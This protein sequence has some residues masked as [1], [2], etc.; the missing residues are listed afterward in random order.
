[1]T[2]P[3]SG[4][5]DQRRCPYVGLQPFEEAD[6]P[7]FFGRERDQRIIIAN[8]L[9]SSLT[10]LYGGSGVGKSSVLMAG[11]LPQLHRERGDTPVVVFREWSRQD[12]YVELKRS[13]IEEAWRTDP[14]R[15]RPSDDESLDE[16]LT[17]CTRAV[18]RPILLILDQFEEYFLYHARPTDPNSFEAQ[19]ARSINRDDVDARFM[20]SL[21]EDGLA[22]LDRFR[23]RIPNLLSNRL[24][25]RHLNSDGAR[26]A[27]RLPLEVW[28]QRYGEEVRIEDELVEALI[29]E[30]RTGQISTSAHAGS[31][32]ARDQSG[33]IE[34]PYL[35]QVLVRL[36]DFEMDSGFRVLRLSTL[37][38]KF[39]GPQAIVRSHLNQVMAEELSA[40]AQAA[41]ASF[42]DRLV[43]PSGAKIA[44]R[45]SD[46][47]DWAE[48]SDRELVSKTLE[49]LASPLLR[50]LRT[51][52]STQDDP[53]STSYEIYHDVLAPAMLDWRQ[54][55][56]AEQERKEAARVAEQDKAKAVKRAKERAEK[57]AL[58]REKAILKRWSVALAI[59]TL[60]AILGW[61]FAYRESLR[62]ESNHL[63]AQSQIALAVD[64]RQGLE[65]ALKAARKT[66]AN[67]FLL[68]GT[69]TAAEDALRRSIQSSRLDWTLEVCG[70]VADLAMSPD[71]SLI[72]VGCTDGNARIWDISGE[73]RVPRATLQHADDTV[74]RR[75]AFL[76]D[77]D[78]LITVGGDTVKLW[79]LDAPQQPLRT[80][81]HG[82]PINEAFALDVDRGRIA[83]AGG[84]RWPAEAKREIKVWDLNGDSDEPI[85]T[86]DT[87]GAWI[88]GLAFSPD[89]CCLATAHV[90]LADPGRKKCDDAQRVSSTAVW[91]IDSGRELLNPKIK[92]ASDAVIFTQD[93]KA[94][95]ATYRDTFVRLW[96]PINGDLGGLQERVR[97]LKEQAAEQRAAA[98]APAELDDDAPATDEPASE[99][100]LTHRTFADEISDAAMSEVTLTPA[101][102]D[103]A[104]GA[105][106]TPESEIPEVCI[107]PEETN[108]LE[109]IFAGHTER[110]RNISISPDGKR[111]ASAGADHL[112]KVWDL[113]TG[114]HLL[115]LKGHSSWVEAVRFSPDG[116]HLATASKD[117]TVKY[118]N[119]SSH[120]GAVNTVAFSPNGKELVTGSSDQKAMVW[121]LGVH[122]PKLLRT[123]DGHT[124]Q[125]YQ[126]AV[127]P[128]GHFIATA[129]FDNRVRI[130]DFQSGKLIASLPHWDS[131]RDVT[132]SD[133]PGYVAT[134]A[135]SGKGRLYELTDTGANQIS[136]ATHSVINTPNFQ[137]ASS[138]LLLGDRKRWITAG[139]DGKL[140][141]WD[142]TSPKAQQ[143]GE[144]AIPDKAGRY[145]FDL[146]LT[147]D[148]KQVAALSY[149]TGRVYVWP[150]EAFSDQNAVVPRTYDVPGTNCTAFAFSP[151]QAKRLLA[152]ACDDAEVHLLD[153]VTGKEVKQISI[154]QRPVVDVAFS[155]ER[156]LLASASLDGSFHVSPL[157]LEDLR[158]QACKLYQENLG[159]VDESDAY[160][161]LGCPGLP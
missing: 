1:M 150:L 61:Y 135:G 26:D 100:A 7:Y 77:N 103:R 85:T 140:K 118:W 143:L 147:P 46:L 116:H 133:P 76:P 102:E 155:P 39:G 27:M 11:V 91:D 92:V 142:F 54:Q 159:T 5:G 78:R 79:S 129:G 51:V 55:Y 31:G 50:I 38:D 48:S 19:L 47:Q 105:I 12:F 122:R 137:Q 95:I 62:A 151:V 49:L 124:D 65:L 126:V 64:A 84:S 41:C 125:V 110:V 9:S 22:K 80:F 83:T 8:L 60:I 139:Y 136:E 152:I 23:A 72:A 145:I 158:L 70:K 119:I 99:G 2:T 52:A 53:N 21:R 42:F 117:G 35:Q 34:A 40:E 89:G 29:K 101:D 157:D 114:E 109:R 18:D 90:K 106:A 132:F 20:L 44:C 146:A 86:I 113:E 71:G 24:Q 68:L 73:K 33:Q 97:E 6:H 115:D 161:E 16:V 138:V 128:S 141:L 58:Q 112:A 131:L 57:D 154:H 69:T 32:A 96:Q 63:A 120:S 123:L 94:L 3:A 134:A 36:W 104:P 75:L 82:A 87:A 67:P 121:R 108:W 30:V 144:I 25:L 81:V 74:V 156:K 28:N 45:A 149:R 130:W 153:V 66:T 10:V 37:M 88:K 13:C 127:D 111:L 43:T 107:P 98:L 93:G 148:G 14:L 4:T 59:A 15:E 17:A 160:S 56:V